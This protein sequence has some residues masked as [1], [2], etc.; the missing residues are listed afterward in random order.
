MV[1]RGK[2]PLT[3]PQ[4]RAIAARNERRKARAA[5]E[6]LGPHIACGV[7][8]SAKNEKTREDSPAKDAD[9][10]CSDQPSVSGTGGV[11]RRIGR[12]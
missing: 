2:A 9:A 3:G 4:R 6:I 5:W 12:R 10:G 1:K 7:A 11:V 8:Q